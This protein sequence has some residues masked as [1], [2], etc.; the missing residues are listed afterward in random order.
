MNNLAFSNYNAFQMTVNERTTHGLA[1][2]AAYTYSH[3]LDIVSLESSSPTSIDARNL[4]LN[5]GSSDFDIRHR[6]TFSPTYAIPG[7]KS[8]GQMLQG[9]AVSGI[10]S[11]YSGLPWSPQDETDDLLGT[12]EFNDPINP[13][14]QTWNYSG[15]R[16]AFTSGSTA[17]PCYVNTDNGNSPMSGCTGYTATPQATSAWSNCVTAATFPTPATPNCKGS[18]SPR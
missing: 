10:V 1:F 5:Y 2:L 13:G 16:S 17:F 12:N 6:F 14:I 3:A 4:R 7:I 15:S 18:H 9:W 11:L 8:P